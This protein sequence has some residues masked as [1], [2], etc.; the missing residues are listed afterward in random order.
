MTPLAPEPPRV[1]ASVIISAHDRR[2]F[3]RDAVESVLAQD[4]DRSM[5]EVIVVKNF[6]DPDIDGFLDRHNA[7]RILCS[8]RSSSLKVAEGLRACRGDVVFLLDDDDLFERN[9]LRTVLDEFTALPSLGFYHNQITPIDSNGAPLDPGRVRAFGLR[10]VRRAWRVLLTDDAK[11]NGLARLA[12]NYPDFNSSSLAIRRDLAVGSFPFLARIE[13]GVDTFFFFVALISSCSLLF[14]DARLTR[15]RIHGENTSLAGGVD[16]DARR[17]RMLA[18]AQQQDLVNRVTREMV[19]AAG[20][21]AV[22]REIDARILITRL[23]IIF[24][25][26]RS[27]RLD[28]A[29]ALLRGIGLRRTFA[30]RENVPSLA[31]AVLFA[32]T[33]R[34]ARTTYEHRVSIR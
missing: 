34:L 29:R 1:P 20:D 5:Y 2:Q 17:A 31:G 22:L 8:A 33:P 4:V 9:K 6:P 30:M 11:R 3:L 14:D 7:R 21:A 10:P 16:R 12:F 19:V 27:V 15:Y 26:P 18:A 23:S 24:R 28:A 25:D 32:L 13:G